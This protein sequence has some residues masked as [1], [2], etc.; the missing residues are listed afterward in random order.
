MSKYRNQL[1]QMSGDIFITDGGTETDLIYSRGFELPCFASYH[2]LND[3]EGYAAITDYFR[4][5]AEIASRYGVG[6]I[7]DSLTY[8]A[9]SDWSE[10]LGYTRDELAAM[11]H[12]AIDLLR[13]VGK[14]YESESTRMVL[15]GC[16][17]PRE[18]AYMPNGLMS[19][20]EAEQYHIE[21]I[22]TLGEAGV[23]MI[24]A[25]TLNE[26]DEAIGITRAAI[27]LNI[28]VVI[29]FSLEIDGTL[30]NGGLLKDAIKKVDEAT[31]NG[32]AYYMIN[33]A[34]P[35]HFNFIFDDE[36]WVKRIRG[37][38]ANASCKSHAELNNSDTLEYGNPVELGLQN[39]ELAKKFKHINV[40]GGC[41]GTNHRH[42]EEICK[43]VVGH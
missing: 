31:D 42:V 1:P 11:N 5:H 18:D 41:C 39:A 20:E 9:S 28:P 23:D 43:A 15:S 34:H 22:T 29:S 32:P 14:E 2:L 26:A 37:I 3:P 16:L 17:G 7:L 4:K 36:N 8:R 21:Q 13:D 25:L 12:K 33:C 27:S 40:F 30:L 24:T 35:T 10:E 19:P 6:F 38:R